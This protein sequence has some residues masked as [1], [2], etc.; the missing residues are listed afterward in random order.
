MRWFSFTSVLKVTTLMNTTLSTTI[1]QD[2]TTQYGHLRPGIHSEVMD[3]STDSQ[4]QPYTDKATDSMDTTL[5]FTATAII[6][7]GASNGISEPSNQAHITLAEHQAPSLEEN[8][9]IP[10]YLLC[11]H[12]KPPNRALY[13]HIALTMSCTNSSPTSRALTLPRPSCPLLPYPPRLL[14][15]PYRSPHRR[16]NQQNA[17]ILRRKGQD[18]WTRRS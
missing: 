12:G 3:N 9:Q 11:K 17:Q 4:K 2:I 18:L 8:E 16:E 7:E 5:D 10:P 14:R 6:T 1:T 15:R 13:Y